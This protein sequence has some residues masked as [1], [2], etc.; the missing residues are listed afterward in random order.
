M[1]QFAACDRM[2]RA[3]RYQGRDDLGR[4]GA[5]PCPTGRLRSEG[6]VMTRAVGHRCRAGFLLPSRRGT[7]GESPPAEGTRDPVRGGRHVVEWHRN[8]APFGRCDE[9]DRFRLDFCGLGHTTRR[10]RLGKRRPSVELLPYVGTTPC[11]AG[12]PQRRLQPDPAPLR[13]ARPTSIKERRRAAAWRPVSLIARDDASSSG[14]I[15]EGDP[16]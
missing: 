1:L 15:Q 2:D 13:R 12:L 5:R 10:P 11:R 3:L 16:T 14:L 6:P 9:I 4:V 8:Q 7:W